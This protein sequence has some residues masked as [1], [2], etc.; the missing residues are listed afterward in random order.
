MTGGPCGEDIA[1]EGQ[2]PGLRRRRNRDLRVRP[3]LLRETLAE[4]GA[5]ATRSA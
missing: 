1:P 2:I 4:M 3:V 5:L